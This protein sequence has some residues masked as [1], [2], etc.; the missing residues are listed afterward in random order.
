MSDNLV[1]RIRELCKTRNA[2]I[3]VHNYQRGDVQDI[4]DFVGD[5]LGLSRTAATTDAQVIVFCGVHFMAETAAIM[6][7]DK[8][9][10]IPD[11]HAGCPMADMITP[12]ELTNFKAEHPDAAVVTYVNSSAAVKAMS[13][14]CCTSANADSVVAGYPEGREILFVPDRNLGSY[15]MRKLD[16]DLV[17]WDGYCPTHQRILPEHVEAVRQA[18]PQAKL[19]VHP[20]CTPAVI[21]MADGVAST[22]GILSFCRESKAKEFIIGTEIGILHRLRKENPLKRFYPVSPMADCP[23]MKL[24]TL[25]KILWCLEDMAPEVA[26]PT[27][28]AEKARAP[29]TRM[30]E[31]VEEP[32]CND[33]CQT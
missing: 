27:E 20:E 5:S 1:P 13:D 21:E 7:P 16:R 19:V 31:V 12:R 29:I 26:V 14:V 33:D 8:K 28:I 25:E 4:G 11:E 18:H 17:L 9:V 23:N 6:C 3:L 30:L 2:V 32:G 24:T 22:T 10:L 15:V